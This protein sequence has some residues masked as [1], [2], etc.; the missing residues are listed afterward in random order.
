MGSRRVE[1]ADITILKTGPSLDWFSN[2]LESSEKRKRQ[3]GCHSFS[4][5]KT[6][7]SK[8]INTMLKDNIEQSYCTKFTTRQLLFAQ[9]NKLHLESI[10]EKLPKS[11]SHRG[12]VRFS[13]M[14][15]LAPTAVTPSSSSSSSTAMDVGNS[16]KKTLPIKAS[17]GAPCKHK[18][19]KR[20]NSQTAAMLLAN[21]FKVLQDDTIFSKNQEQQQKEH[22]QQQRQQKE[23]PSCQ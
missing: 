8:G 11:V 23:Q 9:M 12:V 20:R 10:Q 1:K 7:T 2:H 5:T 18:R 4:T 22:Q 16:V 3:T 17:C 13:P 6:Q 21:C 15:T 14:V 19:Y